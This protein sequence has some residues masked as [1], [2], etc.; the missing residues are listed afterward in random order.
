MNST[1]NSSTSQL[2][3]FPD[4]D[5]GLPAKALATEG[6]RPA[7]QS[8]GDGGTSGI[9]SRLIS[10]ILLTAVIAIAVATGIIAFTAPPNNV[11]SM[12]S[13]TTR[14]VYWAQ[15]GSV[16]HFPSHS[17]EQLRYEPL[18]G[19]AMLQPYILAGNDRFVNGIQ[20]L[21][22][23]GCI[24]GVSLIAKQLG[25]G[26]RGQI[27][28]T[29]ICATIPMGIMQST[30]TQVDLVAAFWLVITIYC[31]LSLKKHF[32]ILNIILLGCS[33]GLAL[34]TKTTNYFFILPFLIW[35]FITTFCRGYHAHFLNL[36]DKDDKV[37]G[38]QAPISCYGVR[39]LSAFF[40]IIFIALIINAPHYYRNIKSFNHPLG[41]YKRK[42]NPNQ[43][44][45]IPRISHVDFNKSTPFE[46]VVPE[47][48][49]YNLL[50]KYA[51]SSSKPF[52]VFIN[53]RIQLTDVGKE[54]TKSNKEKSAKWFFLGR[55]KLKKG[56]QIIHLNRKKGGLPKILEVA[57]EAAEGGEARL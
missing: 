24:F 23:L 31:L 5:L 47:K 42:A 26:F 3:N 7:R 37:I 36:A 51:A 19:F 48:G 39:H 17:L 30:S 11:D 13:H 55:I 27:G 2:P 40:L 18:S 54:I 50:A 8:L 38:G 4:S 45:D 29:V 34:L 41:L 1:L 14:F 57:V 9:A 21:S 20:W 52:S 16:S 15:Q 33:L 12:H 32:S 25:A 22:F 46:I 35:L 10:A 49:I 6:S 44:N 56:H 53:R 28:A 43:Y